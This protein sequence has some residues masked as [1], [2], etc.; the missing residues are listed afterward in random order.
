[1]NTF[2]LLLKNM[3]WPGLAVL[4]ASL[5]GLA[6]Y[7]LGNLPAQAEPVYLISLILIGLGVVSVGVGYV[8][9]KY[10][11][12][13]ICPQPRQFLGALLVGVMATVMMYV[14]L[15]LLI[16]STSIAFIVIPFLVSLLFFTEFLTIRIAQARTVT[17]WQLLSLILVSYVTASGLRELPADV[18]VLAGT[19][20][21]AGLSALIISR[22][23]HTYLISPWVNSFW[24]GWAF[25]GAGILLVPLTTSSGVISVILAVS[26]LPLWL[27]VLVFLMSLSAPVFRQLK[28]K[29][30][31]SKGYMQY[32]LQFLTFMLGVIAMVLTET[33]SLGYSISFFIIII[34]YAVA[35]KRLVIKE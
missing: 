1:M 25:L 9:T 16:F 31:I 11:G 3:S 4:T 5:M 19:M 21:G 32:K 8:V 35:E 22:L 2:R 12:Y 24:N 6:L 10:V 26:L 17:I 15:Q 34:A 27:G 20:L 29:L 18:Q 28:H 13:E 7:L 23:G 14:A 33:F 30:R